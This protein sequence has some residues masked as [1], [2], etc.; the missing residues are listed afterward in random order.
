MI[1]CTVVVSFVNS[2]QSFFKECIM[3]EDRPQKMTL[4]DYSSPIIPQYFTS[5]A[6]PEVQ[7]ANFSYPY[8]LIQL[9]QGNLFHGLPS[10]DPYEHLVTYI[11]ICNTVKIAGV[12]ENATR[13]NLFSFSYHILDIP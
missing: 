3:A 11:D 6:R 8:S 10:E 9:I 5:I 4:D 13:L 12:P 7:A 1:T 2:A